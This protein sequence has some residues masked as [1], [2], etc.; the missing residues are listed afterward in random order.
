MHLGVVLGEHRPRPVGPARFRVGYCRGEVGTVLDRQ[1]LERCSCEGRV[2][3]TRTLLALIQK[4]DRS[5]R[6]ID[7]VLDRMRW[8]TT[9]RVRFPRLL[10]QRGRLTEPAA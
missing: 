9:R 2:D 3:P 6:G 7:R 1:R 5:R 8:H 10:E 4:P